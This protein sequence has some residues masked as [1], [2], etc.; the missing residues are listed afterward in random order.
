MLAAHLIARGHVAITL[1]ARTAFET[2]HVETPQ[3]GVLRSTPA[4]L[5]NAEDAIIVPWVFVATKAYDTVSAAPWLAACTDSHSTIAVL[6]NGVEHT[7][8]LTP[9]AG[10]AAVLPVIVDCPA[11]RTAPGI[12]IQRRSAVLTVESSTAG[13]AFAKLFDET[14]IEVLAVE[15]LT[16]AMWRKLCVNCAGGAISALTDRP[17][18]AFQH[19]QVA[20]LARD[21]I[22]EC[23]D[24]GRAEGAILPD[25]IAEDIVSGWIHA[26]ATAST[27]ML[28]DRRAGKQLEADARNGAVV[29]FGERHGIPTPANRTVAALLGAV[30]TD[31]PA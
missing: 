4:I 26:P 18:G 16:T 22:N 5:C 6:Q 30:N 2:L 9:Y 27:S 28:A 11:T 12:I 13:L 10:H 7:E 25:T 17:M 20:Q 31:A 8:R 23:A 15:D 19:P 21:L 14:A 1:C 24:V 29:R 3:H